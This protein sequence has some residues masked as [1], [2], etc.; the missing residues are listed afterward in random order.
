MDCYLLIP[1]DNEASSI[2]SEKEAGMEMNTGFKGLLV[3]AALL[4]AGCAG[5]VPLTDKSGQNLIGKEAYAQFNLHPD[6]TRGRLY[7]V[8]FQLP[9]AMIPYCAKVQLLE[10]N[11]K[12]LKFREVSTGREFQYIF[13]KGAGEPIEA[14]AAKTFGASCDA[15]KVN[16]LSKTDQEGIRNGRI[17]KGMSKEGVYLAAGFPPANRTPSLD[18]HEWT[19]WK[20]RFNTVIVRFDNKGIVSEVKD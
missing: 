12:V 17:T 15:G 2:H 3:G 19:Y 10:M 11:R 4:A 7:S 18:Y 14:S 5:Q 9:D 8:N 13:H 1:A 6:R 20:N 16:R